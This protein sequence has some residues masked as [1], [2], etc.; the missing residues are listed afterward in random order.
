MT[1]CSNSVKDHVALPGPNPLGADT[2]AV[3]FLSL[4]RF[5]SVL[6]VTFD[7]ILT[8]LERIDVES[9]PSFGKQMSPQTR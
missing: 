9:S 5:V 6:I 4:Y 1:A 8:G 7:Q 2:F 3:V